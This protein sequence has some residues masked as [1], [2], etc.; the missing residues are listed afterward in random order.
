[1]QVSTIFFDYGF[2]SSHTRHG[3]AK[4]DALEDKAQWP[5][6]CNYMYASSTSTSVLRGHL[7]RFHVEEYVQVAQERGWIMQLSSLKGKAAEGVEATSKAPVPFTPDMVANY[8]IRFIV[9]NDQVRLIVHV[10]LTSYQYY[11]SPSMWLKT[12]N[13][14]TS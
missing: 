8:F 13:S 6:L 10:D 7:N 14:V 1:M 4:F 11:C 12:D 3:R 9:A 5:K 2:L